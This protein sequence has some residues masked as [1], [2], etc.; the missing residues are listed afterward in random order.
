MSTIGDEIIKQNFAYD[1]GFA[2]TF[3]AFTRGKLNNYELRQLAIEAQNHR[4]RYFDI[5]EKEIK[6]PSKEGLK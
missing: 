5:T 4:K 1:L 2:N 6:N 3:N